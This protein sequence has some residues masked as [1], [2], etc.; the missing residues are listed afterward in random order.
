MMDLKQTKLVGLTME[1]NLKVEEFNKLC[2]KLESLKKS[3]IDPND[4]R[5]LEL[6]KLFLQN[7]E[8]IVKIKNEMSQFSKNL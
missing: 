8:E 7:Q 5:L 6:K 1:L 2:R 4:E 3:N